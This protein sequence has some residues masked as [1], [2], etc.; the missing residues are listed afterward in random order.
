MK[1]AWFRAIVPLLTVSMVVACG[2]NDN[3]KDPVT[4]NRAAKPTGTP[5]KVETKTPQ[6]PAEPEKQKPQIP[7]AGPVVPGQQPPVI[8]GTEAKPGGPALPGSETKPATVPPVTGDEDG[9][10]PA[11]PMNP[12][13]VTVDNPEYESSPIVNLGTKYTGA[14]TDFMRD[15]LI[16]KMD[17]VQDQANKQRNQ[18]ASERVQSARLNIDSSTG[19]VLV[20]VKMDGV[21]RDIHL[22]GSLNEYGTARLVPTGSSG[23]VKGGTIMCL[24]RSADTCFAT[25]ARLVVGEPGRRGFINIL[26]RKTSANFDFKLPA[27][28]ASTREFAR[29]LEMFSNTERRTG[30]P[31][32]LRE[33]LVES[34]EVIKGRSGIKVSMITYENEV[35][36]ASGP[37][38]AAEDGGTLT[39]V[40]MSREPFF[41][42]LVDLENRR[43]FKTSIHNSIPEIR[44]V[45]NDGQ[46]EIT[47]ALLMNPDANN[48]R[49]SLNVTIVR[50]H[51]AIRSM[52][53]IEDL[54]RTLGY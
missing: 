53:E 41:Q 48:Q 23:P 29:I 6:L 33:I 5:E 15:Y 1:N 43:A 47:L 24:D 16:Q 44:M 32:S 51:R 25:H 12:G 46:K 10:Q 27:K 50:Q 38:L 7:P 22:A 45:T 35:I 18:S 2:K 19:D 54:A 31:N 26:F 9:E 28:A 37:L 20:T 21:S 11:G 49:D 52:S 4:R 42:D 13:P 8:P 30:L 36:V 14:G 39:N 34:F 3:S 40:L 17:S